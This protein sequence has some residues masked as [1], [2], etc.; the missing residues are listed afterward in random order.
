[1]GKLKKYFWNS[2]EYNDKETSIFIPTCGRRLKR[3]MK[4]SERVIGYAKNQV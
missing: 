1:M 4:I 3:K 2:G